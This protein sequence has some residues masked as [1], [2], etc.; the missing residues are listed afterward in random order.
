M[1]QTLEKF[2]NIFLEGLEKLENEKIEEAIKKFKES[3]EIFSE[4]LDKTEEKTDISEDLE[5]FFESESWKETLQKYVNLYLDTNDIKSL[6]SELET[7]NKNFDE[8][9]NEKE[10]DDE[11]ISKTFDEVLEALE[12]IWGVTISKID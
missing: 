11:L 4:I 9:K 7:L 8:L 1:K 2:Q 12:K 10:K 3:S 5:K 6:K